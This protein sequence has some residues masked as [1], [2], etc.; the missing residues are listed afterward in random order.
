MEVEELVM[1][2]MRMMKEGVAESGS[3]WPERES[4]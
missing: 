1:R 3:D 4:V 2:Q